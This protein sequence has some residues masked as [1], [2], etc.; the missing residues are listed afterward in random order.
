[1]G[2]LANVHETQQINPAFDDKKLTTIVQ[3]FSLNPEEM[4]RELHL[5]A[6]ELLDQGKV[7]EAWQVLLTLTP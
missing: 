3:Y 1:M 5:Y 7:A 6:V 4:E 2:Q